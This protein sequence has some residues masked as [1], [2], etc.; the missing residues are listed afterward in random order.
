MF[1]C[2][3]YSSVIGIESVLHLTCQQGERNEM[4]LNSLAN[5]ANLVK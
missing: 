5:L 1:S 2:L 3:Y 4:C